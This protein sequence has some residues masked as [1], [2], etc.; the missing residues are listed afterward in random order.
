MNRNLK[1]KLI[2]TKFTR[3]GSRLKT[4]SRRNLKLN[5]GVTLIELIVY[6]SILSVFILI[7]TDILVT[8]LNTQTSTES[9]SAVAADGRYIY[10]RITYDIN[11]A[12]SVSVPLNLGDTSNSL[13]LNIAG[14]T[15][16][17]SLNADNLQI[18]DL[19][20]SYSLNSTDTKLSNLQF[21]RIGNANGKNTFQFIFTVT[22]RIPLSGGRSDSEVF[23]TT[24]GL[25]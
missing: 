11:R 3:A 17:Y 14:T 21:K 8:I 13:I 12:Q 20:G 10:A 18:T 6:F 1:F 23:Q 2:P 16:T 25:R 9:T 4:I 22:G 24:A 19:T 7:L 15:Y 5:S